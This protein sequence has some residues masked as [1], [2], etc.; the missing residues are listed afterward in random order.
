MK[1][2]KWKAADFLNFSFISLIFELLLMAAM[3]YVFTSFLDGD[4]GVVIIAFLILAPLLSVQVLL[5]TRKI[6]VSVQAPTYAAKGKRFAVRLILT[7]GGKLPV[8]FVK[9]GVEHTANF[10]A[11]DPRPVQSAMMPARPLEIE[12]G[13]TAQYAGCGRIRVPELRI[14]DY[15]GML[16]CY[17][18]GTAEEISIG[19][20]PEIPSLTGA[21]VLLH[22]VSDAVLTQDEEE[23]E[24]SAAYSSVSM[25]G[26]IHRDYVPGDNLRRINWKLSAKRNKL[27]VRMDEAASTVR[28]A[29]L[30]D[31][32]AENTPESLKRRELLMEGALGLLML[33]V[34]QG[35][36]CSLRFAAGGE[37]KCL[38]PESEDAV[39]QAAL[40]LA[41]ADF[42]GGDG[43]I[44]SSAAQEKAG[45]FLVYTANPD[46]AL[47]HA[48]H[49]LRDKGD[50]YLVVPRGT[51]AAMLTEA[52]AVWELSED[53]TMTAVQ[54]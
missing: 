38:F 44:D 49:A 6:H 40:E 24:S 13:M 12:F 43:R 14:S 3:A 51:S 42:I 5:L 9:C 28:P 33:L 22:A 46:A 23:E 7:A 17:S 41:T 50:L 18:E 35:V 1:R 11:D 26:Y 8:P 27:M 31:L 10:A 52:Q 4:I 34:R 25:P 54:K 53:F 21:A 47:A 19:V 32:Q 16:T 29:I 36:P 39:R 20:I 30:L 2:C 45:A 48:V 15:L 37:M